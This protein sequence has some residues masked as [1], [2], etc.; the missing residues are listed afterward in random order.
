MIDSI[1]Y[2]NDF[3]MLVFDE[4]IPEYEE[5]MLL[6][7]SDNNLLVSNYK[8]NLLHQHLFMNVLM[9]NDIP[10]VMF[11]LFQD[12]SMPKN[13]ARCYNRYFTVP[14]KRLK[15]QTHTKSIIRKG[16]DVVTNFYN[17]HPSYHT[18]LGI[19]SLFFTR[20]VKGLR[21]DLFISS[22]TNHAFTQLQFPYLYKN[23]PQYFFVYGSSNW[24]TGLPLLSGPD[25]LDI[26]SARSG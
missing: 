21:K 17:D 10:S 26:K 7:A 13:V 8:K 19:D 11:G 4:F 1:K 18:S 3:T 6:A 12:S 9:I 22:V 24:Y 5:V 16:I 20:N 15:I 25:N 23:T 14:S 2:D